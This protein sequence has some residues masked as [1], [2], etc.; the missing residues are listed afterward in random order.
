MPRKT[1]EINYSA[2]KDVHSIP[3][4]PRWR[5]AKP[6]RWMNERHTLPRDVRVCLH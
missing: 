5:E 6:Y 1:A 2:M 4:Y 3:L